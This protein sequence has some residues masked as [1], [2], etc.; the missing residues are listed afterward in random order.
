MKRMTFKKKKLI[1]FEYAC[2]FYQFLSKWKC[3]R[4]TFE[5]FNRL[6]K[7]KIYLVT[8]RPFREMLSLI[9][10]WTFCIYSH[11]RNGGC[12]NNIYVWE[13][14][15]LIPRSVLA[16]CIFHSTGARKQTRNRNRRS[17]KQGEE[18]N[19]CVSARCE[20]LAETII[21]IRILLTIRDRGRNK[22]N[23]TK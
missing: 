7:I 5:S 16:H 22:I 14:F 19:N 18:K 23:Q 21:I 17:E 8:S 4:I 20:P 3:K 11:R 6:L 12:E 13:E 10:I 2:I 15:L 9:S 1:Y